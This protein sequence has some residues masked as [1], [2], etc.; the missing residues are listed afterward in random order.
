MMSKSSC[1]RTCSSR[2]FTTHMGMNTPVR[3][4]DFKQW[5]GHR[6][7]HVRELV[8]RLCG[9]R[10]RHQW[11]LFSLFFSQTKPNPTTGL[12]GPAGSLFSRLSTSLHAAAV[13][14]SHPSTSAT[15]RRRH[16]P[17]SGLTMLTLLLITLPAEII[18][19]GILDG[20]DWLNLPILFVALRFYF[21][22]CAVHSPSL[23]STFLHLFRT[24]PGVSWTLVDQL[25]RYEIARKS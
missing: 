8:G 9:S 2:I 16:E 23:F 22:C 20:L 3:S 13:A 25:R 11:Y 1:P 10:R 12:P 24:G 19:L 18:F 17:S 14:L 7:G 4:Y 5:D 6:T 15:V 21:F